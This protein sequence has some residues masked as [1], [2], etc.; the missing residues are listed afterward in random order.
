[1]NILQIRYLLVFVFLFNLFN[2][3][4]NGQKKLKKNEIFDYWSKTNVLVSSQD[5]VLRNLI[6]F[7]S[8]LNRRLS[9]QISILKNDNIDTFGVL[10]TSYPGI[11]TSDSCINGNYPTDLYVCWK[12]INK[13]FTK[14]ITNYC[15][16]NTMET[17][18]SLFFE[19]YQTHQQQIQKEYILPV[20]FNAEI[21]KDNKVKYSGETINHEPKYIL[22]C[23]L[24]NV[25]KL[26]VFSENDVLNRKS[27]FYN[28]NIN[29]K[30]YNWFILIK[31]EIQKSFYSFKY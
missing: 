23:Q 17:Q 20:I 31:K 18:S 30:V 28:D 1:M 10:I 4:L 6:P 5:E 3:E 29:S 15:E 26:L 16:Y 9:Q 25:Y 14:K 12:L 24:G 13:K 7:D 19:Y 21:N 27:I 22:Y 8:N 11:L 2:I